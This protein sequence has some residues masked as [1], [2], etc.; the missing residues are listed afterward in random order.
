MLR[1]RQVV[2]LLQPRG[3]GVASL[4]YVCPRHGIV[5]G[6]YYH[7]PRSDVVRWIGNSWPSWID[8]RRPTDRMRDK[9]RWVMGSVGVRDRVRMRDWP[10]NEVV[11]RIGDRP[12]DRMRNK[13]RW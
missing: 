7:C 1:E 5:R 6:M 9:R 13:R 10:R 8:N 11:R 3:L 2:E 4:C 12:T